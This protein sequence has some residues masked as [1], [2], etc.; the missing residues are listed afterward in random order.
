MNQQA[1]LKKKLK[2]INNFIW[3]Q[4]QQIDP[5]VFMFVNLSGFHLKIFSRN[6][7]FW[8]VL[9]K[10]LKISTRQVKWSLKFREYLAKHKR[11]VVV[12]PAK[13]PNNKTNSCASKCRDRSFKCV[14]LT[15]HHYHLHHLP[16]TSFRCSFTHSFVHLLTWLIHLNILYVWV[17]CCCYLYSFLFFFL[18]VVFF[19]FC[20]YSLSLFIIL[21]AFV[22]VIN[23][24][25]DIKFY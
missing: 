1:K 21:I 6:F 4:Q 7:I 10:I 12:W 2:K 19:F 11:V 13:W 25:L 18:Q 16:P 15:W 20:Y 24:Y 9:L 8:I 3:W 14:T 17:T 5:S 23:I 22:V